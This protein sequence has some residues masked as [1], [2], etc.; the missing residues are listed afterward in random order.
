MPK[1][2][3]RRKVCP[4]F[5]FAFCNLAM[6]SLVFLNQPWPFSGFIPPKLG[7]IPSNPGFISTR[8]RC[9]DAWWRVGQHRIGVGECFGQDKANNQP[10]IMKN[11][12]KFAFLTVLGDSL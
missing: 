12:S 10:S 11:I 8:F 1:K 4:V 5:I 6:R 7:F 9:G 2:S 3:S